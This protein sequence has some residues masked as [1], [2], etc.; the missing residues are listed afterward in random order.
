[1]FDEKDRTILTILQREARTSNAEIARQLGM[2]PSAILERI[3]KLEAKGA[4][5]RY[6]TRLDAAT[7]G[8]GLTAFCFVTVLEPL[9][10]LD[11]GEALTKIPEVQEVHY[12]AGEDCYLVKIRAPDTE[13]LSKLIRE[14]F[15]SIPG[16]H[17]TRTTLVLSTLKE[18]AAVSLDALVR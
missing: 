13:S 3:R 11:G 8:M 10:Q 9:S 5:K 2:A 12:I 14:K 7:V 17:R 1:M 6:E 15:G 4:I 18:T 16:M